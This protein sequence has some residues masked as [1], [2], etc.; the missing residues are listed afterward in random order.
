MK[1]ARAMTI[2]IVV[3]LAGCSFATEPN[4]FDFFSADRTNGVFFEGQSVSMGSVVYGSGKIVKKGFEETEVLTRSETPIATCLVGS[5]F[6]MALPKKSG[7]DIKKLQCGI[8]AFA[9]TKCT[10]D[11]SC[12]GYLIRREGVKNTMPLYYSY[13]PDHGVKEISFDPRGLAFNTLFL[14][15]KQ[16][17]KSTSD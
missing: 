3:L 12:D 9:V 1:I 13:I 2:V 5:D 8:V 4:S 16:G 17:P 11:D 10:K 7:L 6:V 14:V 15:G